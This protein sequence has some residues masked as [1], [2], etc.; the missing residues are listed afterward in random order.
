MCMQQLRSFAFADKG[1][2]IRGVSA[3]VGEATKAAVFSFREKHQL[4]ESAW[5]IRVYGVTKT[6]Q[7]DVWI[8]KQSGPM[9]KYPYTLFHSIAAAHRIRS[10]L[11]GLLRLLPN[12]H[13]PSATASRG[14]VRQLKAYD[15]SSM[16]EPLT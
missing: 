8:G 15:K 7:I 14:S 13:P 12:K 2:W 16:F 9:C 4:S 10:L 11:E 6:D 3:E 1:L 5:Q